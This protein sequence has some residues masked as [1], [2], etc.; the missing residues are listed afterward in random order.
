M[1]VQSHSHGSRRKM[2]SIQELLEFPGAAVIKRSREITAYFHMR[3][4]MMN[5]LWSNNPGEIDRWAD[6]GGPAID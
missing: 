2:A 1:A 4:H 5:N 6:D 3:Q